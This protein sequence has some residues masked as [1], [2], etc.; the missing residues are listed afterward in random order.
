MRQPS[1]VECSVSLARG[2]G[3]SGLS[4]THGA[5]LIDSTP[6]AMQTVSSPDAIARLALNAASIP[7]PHSRFTV[8]PGI[9]VGRPASSTAMRATLRL[10]SPAWLA[11]PKYTSSG[12]MPGLRSANARTT[13]AAR[14]SG[15][16]V[17]SEPP[18]LPTGVR[19]ASGMKTSGTL[20]LPQQA[21]LVLGRRVRR[22]ELVGHLQLPGR[23]LL[24]LLE[25]HAGV[26]RRHRQLPVDPAQNAEVGDHDLIV[27][28]ERRLEVEL[29]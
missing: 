14:S 17:A 19:T 2:N 4:I 8:A 11:S 7:E 21:Q 26:Q 22:L 28:A 23:R 27:G 15:R 1:V 10:S 16:V 24:R 29:A 18:S 25:R 6:P 13:V 5:R 9:E 12:S 20:E 3:L